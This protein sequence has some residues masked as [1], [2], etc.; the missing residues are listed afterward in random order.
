MFE[1]FYL[2]HYRLL[3]SLLHQGEYY[4]YYYQQNKKSCYYLKKHKGRRICTIT[5]KFRLWC[6]QSNKGKIRAHLFRLLSSS[7][8]VHLER[9]IKAS[10]E[11]YWKQSKQ[12]IDK[13]DGYCTKPLPVA[14]GNLIDAVDRKLPGV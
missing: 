6:W 12:S 14:F 2:T 13:Y 3:S 11:I 8:T 10:N 7:S 5:I 9:V 1:Y 4:Y